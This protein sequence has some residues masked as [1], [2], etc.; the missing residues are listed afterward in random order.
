[1]TGTRS[2]DKEYVYSLGDGKPLPDELN[3]EEAKKFIDK[4]A[5]Y[6]VEHFFI[7]GAEACGEPLMRKDFSELIQ[8][9]SDKGMEPYV[10]I[11]GHLI[12]ENIARKLADYNCKMIVTI[13]GLK[14]VDD[15]LRGEGA[16]EASMNA[17]R[18]CAKEGNLFTISVVN[19]KYVVDQI[20]ELV[21]LSMDVGSEGF[22]LASLIPQPIGVKEQLEKL[23]PLEPTP[24]EREK[25]LNIIYNLSKELGNQIRLLP[26]EMFYNRV[27]KQKDPSIELSSRCSVCHNLESNEWLEV[28]DNGDAYGCST[29]N[30]LFG[31]IKRDSLDQIMDKS[32]TDE[33]VKKL[34]NSK[35]IKGKCG[36]CEFN[37]ICGGCRA[38]AYIFSGDMFAYDPACPYNPKNTM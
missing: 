5:D 13:A 33:T 20:P 37:P 23:G 7:C 14:K 36:Y 3:T 38:R 10:K 26:Y 1:M 12:N 31:N 28:L 17:A 24:I 35:N 27:L 2:Y 8:Y 30:L 22:S 11:S 32:R 15:F 6:G 18:L 21:K 25:E 29:L 16:H 9:V 4:I 34:A 19:T